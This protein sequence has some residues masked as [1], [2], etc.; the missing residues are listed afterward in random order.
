MLRIVI[1]F[2]CGFL[3]AVGAGREGFG[4]EG[5]LM[6]PGSAAATVLFCRHV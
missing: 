1:A 6:G 3:A 5:E 2:V 4:R